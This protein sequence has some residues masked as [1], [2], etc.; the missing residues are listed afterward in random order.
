L[1]VSS[2][3]AWVRLEMS[4][5]RSQRL[6]CSDVSFASGEASIS[7]LQATRVMRVSR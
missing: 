5:T 1:T 3:T 2:D 4:E 6:S 7:A